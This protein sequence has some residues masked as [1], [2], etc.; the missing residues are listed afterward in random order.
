MKK[1]MLFYLVICLQLLGQTIKEVSIDFELNETAINRAIVSQFDEPNFIFHHFTGVFPF[2]G[3]NAPYDAQLTR[4]SVVIGDNTIGIHLAFSFTTTVGG[5]EYNYEFDVTPSIRVDETSIK[6]SEVVAFIENLDEKINEHT[7][8]P[9]AIRA[10]L[11]TLYNIYE[12]QIYASNLYNAVLDEINSIEFIQ[13]RAFS[14]T[15]FGISTDFVPGK[16]V[17]KVS[18]EITYDETEFWSFAKVETNTDYIK[19]GSNIKCTITYLKVYNQSV[20]QVYSNDDLSVV[21]E[22]DNNPTPYDY[23]AMI[24][25]GSVLNPNVPGLIVWYVLYK[26]DSTFYFNKYAYPSNNWT[27]PN[28]RINY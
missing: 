15:D 22:S 20:Q 19:F 16:F 24:N 12:P 4:P 23:Y 10:L 5:E 3:E 21:L 28:I 7:E 11:I 13:Q 8:I 26:I 1:I 18:A 6:A 2:L 25:I 17:I 27:L 9:I 14:V